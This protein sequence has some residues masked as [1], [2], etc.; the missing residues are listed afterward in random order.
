MALTP[1]SCRTT[2][3]V[4]PVRGTLFPFRCN[5]VTCSSCNPPPT[6][7]PPDGSSIADWLRVRGLGYIWGG[8]DLDTFAP[9]NVIH[10]IV[11]E[12]DVDP[13]V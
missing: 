2:T 13:S 11:M 6:S 9:S 3:R 10:R 1:S 4:C 12:I 7:N 5:T 8:M